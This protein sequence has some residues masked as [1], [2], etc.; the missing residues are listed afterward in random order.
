MKIEGIAIKETFSGNF[1]TIS[2]FN[3]T[4]WV[5]FDLVPATPIYS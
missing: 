1:R 3:M 5:Y 2:D 4:Y